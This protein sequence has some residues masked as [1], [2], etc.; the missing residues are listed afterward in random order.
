MEELISFFGL[1]VKAGRTKDEWDQL[2]KERG[3]DTEGERTHIS[4]NYFTKEAAG[5]SQGGLVAHEGLRIQKGG[6][7]VN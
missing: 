1:R 6:E 3:R 4:L 2:L 7:G 5:G